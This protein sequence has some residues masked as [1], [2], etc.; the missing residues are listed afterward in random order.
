MKSLLLYL[1]TVTPVSK[2][3]SRVS[4]EAFGNLFLG[5]FL[6][7]KKSGHAF[8]HSFHWDNIFSKALNSK[9]VE[10]D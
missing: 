9:K 8:R 2:K 6:S 3:T 1:K 7:R 5:V 10:V 4:G